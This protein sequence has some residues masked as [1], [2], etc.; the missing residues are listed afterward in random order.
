MA[1]ARAR[2]AGTRRADPRSDPRYRRV[3]D[4][5]HAEFDGDNTTMLRMDLIL[6]LKDWFVEHIQ[7]TDALYR[8]YVA[9]EPAAAAATECRAA[10]PRS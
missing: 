3:V 7:E 6:L 8:P 5:L 4:K 9:G 1:V 2:R 10:D